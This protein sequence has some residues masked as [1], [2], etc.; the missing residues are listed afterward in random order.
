MPVMP[1]S[2][3]GICCKAT[4]GDPR[5]NNILFKVITVFH[6]PV[7]EDPRANDCA[8]PTPTIC[9]VRIRACIPR[10]PC[11]GPRLKPSSAWILNAE[12]LPVAV[13]VGESRGT[14][15][16]KVGHLSC[17]TVTTR[18]RDAVQPA[19]LDKSMLTDLFSHFHKT[20]RTMKLHGGPGLLFCHQT[21]IYIYI[22]YVRIFKIYTCIKTPTNTTD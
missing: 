19:C 18:G 16:L 8:S 5:L 6:G 4:R 14:A 9:K 13:E 20:K 17:D 22:I 15:A 7:V 1:P 10:M 2:N 21:Y 11:A 3:L 12:C